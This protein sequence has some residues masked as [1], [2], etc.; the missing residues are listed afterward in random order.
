MNVKSD[1]KDNR[2]NIVVKSR[3][4]RAVLPNNGF[5]SAP[6]AFLS[7]FQVMICMTIYMAGMIRAHK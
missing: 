6:F 5:S 2:R 4:L 3:R 1:Q 7:I